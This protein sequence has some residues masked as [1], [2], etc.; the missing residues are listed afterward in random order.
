[1]R[2]IKNDETRVVESKELLTR[3]NDLLEEYDGDECVAVMMWMLGVMGS[4]VVEA[5]EMT[6][7]QMMQ[8]F[9]QGIE[10]ALDL[11]IALEGHDG[12]CH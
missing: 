5:G 12:T 4:G 1:M 3:L 9:I 11:N 2:T 10:S 7:Q 8:H 6:K